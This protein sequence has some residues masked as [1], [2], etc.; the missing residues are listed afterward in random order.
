MQD[1]VTRRLAAIVAVDVAGYSRLMG[2]DE[3]GTLATL[4]AHRAETDALA[5]RFGG[6]I[7]GT[8]GDGILFEFPSVIMYGHN[9]VVR[10][11]RRE[12]P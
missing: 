3:A 8:A 4:K 7:V 10:N 11:V 5:D 12:Q 2:A 6:R 9:G 1:K